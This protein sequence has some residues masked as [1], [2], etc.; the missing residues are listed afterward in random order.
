MQMLDRHDTVM[1]SRAFLLW[2]W[3]VSESVARDDRRGDEMTRLGVWATGM[4]S[5]IAVV[6][7]LVI[8]TWRAGSVLEERRVLVDVG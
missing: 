2:P 1:R 8:G 5:G 7:L 4:G 6:A 3:L